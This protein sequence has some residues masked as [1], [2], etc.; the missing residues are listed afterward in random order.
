MAR[1]LGIRLSSAIYHVA[2]R[3]NARQTIVHNGA[4]RDLP[5]CHLRA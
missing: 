4:D 1:L 3:R 2:A 5:R